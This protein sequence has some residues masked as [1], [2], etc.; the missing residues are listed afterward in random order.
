MA[1]D[2]YSEYKNIL[3]G[4]NTTT[5]KNNKKINNYKAR[6][7]ASGVDVDKATDKRNVVEK[8][9][10]LKQDQNVLFDLFE[11]LNRPQQALFGAWESGQ[12]GKDVLQGALQGLTGNKETQFKDILKNYGMEDTKG[13]LDL[14]DVLGFAGDVVLDPMDLVPLAGYSKFSKALEGGE[15]LRKA[16]K[17]LKTGSDLVM[18]G[19]TQGIKGAVKGADKGIEKVL[20]KLDETKGVVDNVTG[21]TT[22]LSYLNP[23]AKTATNL[24][25]IDKATQQLADG[26]IGRLQEYK[27]I[28]NDLSNMFVVPEF[29]KSAFKTQRNEDYNKFKTTVETALSSDKYRQKIT[30]YATE[31]GLDADQLMKDM[32]TFAES[33]M[34]RVVDNKRILQL[35]KEG[36]LPAYDE[37]VDALNEMVEQSVPKKILK[38]NPSLFE[39]GVDEKTG[40][41]KL[42]KGFKVF[43]DIDTEGT[44]E[45]ARRYN[46]EQLAHIAE[47][48]K[49]YI[50]DKSYRQ[51]F[52]EVLGDVW[53]NNDNALD[54]MMS[55]TK[56]KSKDK[57]LKD[58]GASS[59]INGGIIDEINSQVDKGLGTGLNEKYDILTNDSYIPHTLTAEGKS[60]RE[61][62]D[63]LMKTNPT[64][65]NV[66][67]LK[68]RTR[69]GSID[70][71]NAEVTKTINELDQDVLNKY[72]NLLAFKK[73]NAKFMEDNILKAINN[74][75]LDESN[76]IIKNAA[77]VNKANQILL[78]DTF[79]N[80]EQI[81][82]TKDKIRKAY[83]LG[84]NFEVK[85]LTKQLNELQDKSAVK[86]LTSTDNKIPK[87]YTRLS[88]KEITDITS[89]YDTL[90]KQLGIDGGFEDLT[91]SLKKYGGDVAIDDTILQM[92]RAGASNNTRT[93]LSKL[94]NTYINN[95][96]KWKTAS[97][98]FLLNNL[99][100]NSSNLSLSGISVDEQAKY[101][102]TILDIMQN[103]EKYAMARLSGKTLDNYANG[104]ADY[105]ELYRSLGFD[106]SALQLNEM[107]KEIKEL[108]TG[109]RKLSGFKDYLVNGIPYFNNMMNN[110]MDMS[111]RL[112]VMLKCL[113]DPSYMSKINVDN[114]YDAISKVMFDPQMLTSWEKKTAKNVI[115]FYTYAKNNLV[116]HATNI[117]DNG[118]KY[119]NLIKEIKGLQKLA[120]DNNSDNLAD[121]IK[122]SLYVPIPALDEKGNYII[123]RS[124][125]PFGQF[126]ET[127]DDPLSQFANMLSPTIKSPIEN[128]LNK[129]LYTGRDIESFAG[130]KSTNIPLLT[131]KQEKL[132]ADFTGLDVPLK[133]ISRMAKGIGEG[134]GSG[135][136]I[137]QSIGRGLK[138]TVT[139]SGNID[140]DKMYKT[141]QDIDDLQELIKQYEQKGY[142]IA[143]INELKKANNNGV[144]ANINA[145][146]NKYGIK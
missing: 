21:A 57:L 104:I 108:F 106:T 143:S 44:V 9:L 82:D 1:T 92:F 144:V 56:R 102:K 112:V 124:S 85:K 31:H 107:P 40:K 89:K 43:N 38:S 133:N 74:K 60:I 65:G 66:S 3:Y 29:V 94:Y 122:T 2:K 93:G 117:G 5:S 79:G 132:L 78:K 91:K 41:V 76:S 36:K 123:L 61:D 15:G 54:F 140:T 27:Q 126:V 18:Q 70:E 17:E 48:N 62:L 63:N 16:S 30:K 68:S 77:Q 72:P 55:T 37:V 25:P 71:I 47:I 75:Y 50:K 105:W 81:I 127:L 119:Y 13:K 22:K 23:T 101:G 45:I 109:E 137:L 103:G 80:A 90:N 135:D 95:F 110:K 59:T 24:M 51:L 26:V 83:E 6:L 49:Q 32:V 128:L 67:L 130:Q 20:T 53:K 87:G 145:I 99:I 4:G 88:N 73:S 141:Y 7:E 86:F 100:G 33:H 10:N 28:K 120:T 58:I 97:P 138:N 84:D 111:A 116:Y 136:N 42:G 129:N 125:L 139:I 52:D 46:N 11:L 98:T 39:I 113:D 8:A 64:R 134:L 118:K 69:L 114:I 96:R 19:V 14:V 34:D 121:Y 142:N 146:F 12:Q 35:A 115:P 131:K